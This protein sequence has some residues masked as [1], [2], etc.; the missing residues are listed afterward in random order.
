MLSF[1]KMC[2]EVEAF[3]EIPRFIE[4]ELKGGYVVQVK[5]DIPWMP[6]KCSH[7]KNFGHGNKTCQMREKNDVATGS[8][9]KPT[10]LKG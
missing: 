6:I 2:V 4:V 1:A 7:C 3:M 8:D 10:Y 5:V 9:A